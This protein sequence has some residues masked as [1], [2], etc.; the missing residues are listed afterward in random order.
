MKILAL[1]TS[2]MR[3]S[4]AW[5]SSGNTQFKDWEDIHTSYAQMYQ[6]LSDE[7]PTHIIVCS[8]PGRYSGIRSGIAFCLGLSLAQNIPIYTV[9]AFDLIAMKID[10]P[11]FTIVLDA[12]KS[13]AYAQ[14]FIAKKPQPMT[15]IET[16]EIPQSSYG[17]LEHPDVQAITYDASDMIR[18]LQSNPDASPTSNPEA[19]YLRPAV[20]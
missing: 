11:D 5:H 4:I 13:Q 18:W 7:Q 20:D 17:P 8:G 2:Q 15:L 3:Y 10:Q 14:S 16:T 19:L 12:R 1:D 9:N 6:A